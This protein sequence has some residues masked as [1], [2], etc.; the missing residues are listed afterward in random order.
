MPQIHILP[1][2]V[3]QLIAAGEVVERPASAIKEMVENSIDASA[4]RI[5]VE[6]QHGRRLWYRKG[7]CAQGVYQPCHLQDRN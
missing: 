3:Y 5:T 1:K 7:G 4:T 6:I 2:S